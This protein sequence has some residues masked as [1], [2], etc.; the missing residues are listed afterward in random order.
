MDRTQ[1]SRK[2]YSAFR[3][4][5]TYRRAINCVEGLGWNYIPELNFSWLSK[6][7]SREYSNTCWTFDGP[8]CRTEES[9]IH[10]CHKR[11]RGYRRFSLKQGNGRE[12]PEAS[13]EDWGFEEKQCNISDVWCNAWS[14]GRSESQIITW[15]KSFIHPK[16]ITVF[17]T[18]Q[19]STYKHI[20]ERIR[21]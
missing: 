13:G 12:T 7:W 19:W 6:E 14:E 10:L 2:K 15:S 20:P 4:W 11:C 1:K 9:W 18:W 8:C 3:H 16:I 17:A 21:E 5:R